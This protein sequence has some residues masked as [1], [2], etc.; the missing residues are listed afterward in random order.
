LENA[1]RAR[2]KPEAPAENGTAGD[3]PFKTAA[4]GSA[5]CVSANR[6][7]HAWQSCAYILEGAHVHATS[8]GPTH[9]IHRAMEQGGISD[10]ATLVALLV[11]SG[12]TPLLLLRLQRLIFPHLAVLLQAHVAV[13]AICTMD[14][15]LRTPVPAAWLAFPWDAVPH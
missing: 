7:I 6:T 10:H 8:V 4:T 13:K 15:A 5:H 3:R 14:A 1:C 9:V 11:A 2:L 12:P